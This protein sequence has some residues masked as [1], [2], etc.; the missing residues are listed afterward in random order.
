MKRKEQ[1]GFKI[2]NVGLIIIFLIERWKIQS[3]C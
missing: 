2:N 1:G 3:V